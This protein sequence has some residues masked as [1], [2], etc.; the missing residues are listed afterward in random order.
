MLTSKEF[1]EMLRDGI[2]KVANGEMDELKINIAWLDDNLDP[3]DRKK[4]TYQYTRN[5]CDREA[6]KYGKGIRART[7]K[8]NETGNDYWIIQLK[9]DKKARIVNEKDLPALEERWKRKFIEHLLKLQPRITDLEG[10]E[11]KGA[12]IGIERFIAMIEDM[13]K[14][15]E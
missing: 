8:C 11:L 12:A 13:A 2:G 4:I 7:H 10:D 9:G 15:D 1:C 14:G 6:N 5:T 3:I